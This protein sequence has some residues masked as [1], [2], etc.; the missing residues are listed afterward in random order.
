M[1]DSVSELVENFIVGAARQL[2]GRMF[3]DREAD[4]H[5]PGSPYL[6]ASAVLDAH[7]QARR[8]RLSD[9]LSE[10]IDELRYLQEGK[11]HFI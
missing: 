7:R 3:C 6:L 8:Q 5:T 4:L 10:T 2:K 1:S 11:L 9:Q